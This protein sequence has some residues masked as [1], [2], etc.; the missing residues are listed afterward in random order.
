MFFYE[1]Q[2]E[3]LFDKGIFSRVEKSGGKLQ[4]YRN[5]PKPAW[6]LNFLTVSVSYRRSHRSQKEGRNA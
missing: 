5:T 4:N 3:G 1:R 6:L 2:K